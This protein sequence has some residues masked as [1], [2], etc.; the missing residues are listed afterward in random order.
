MTGARAQFVQPTDPGGAR[1]EEASK[2][3]VQIFQ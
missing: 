1:F 2:V 3:A